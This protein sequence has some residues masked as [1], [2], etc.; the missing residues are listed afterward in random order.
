MKLAAIYTTLAVI[1]TFAN[2][3][4]QELAI[5]LY[6][7]A[8]AILL[9]VLFGTAVGLVVK[10]ILDKRYIFGFKAR[11]AKHD[12]QTF[13]LYTLMGVLTTMVFWGFEFGFHYLFQ[14]KWM[15]YLGGALGLALGYIL[16]Y[17]LDKR[18]VFVK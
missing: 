16:K 10:Y 5:R 1:A 15:R 6:G 3:A 17:Q 14:D 18:Y 9:S 11:D 7:G 13:A 8:Y 4:A 12:G 2:L